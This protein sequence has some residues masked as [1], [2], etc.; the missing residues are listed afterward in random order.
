CSV[1][2]NKGRFLNVISFTEKPIRYPAAFHVANKL[3]KRTIRIFFLTSFIFYKYQ[4]IINQK[5]KVLN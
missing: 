4:I 3:L 2:N 1:K 5:I